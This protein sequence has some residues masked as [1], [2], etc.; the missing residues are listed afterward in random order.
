M[1]I[2]WKEIPGLPGFWASSQ[3]RIRG[4]RR[5]RVLY[6]HRKYL[7]VLI[8]NRTYTVHSLVALAFLGPRPP[9]AEIRHL[10]DDKHNNAP[11]NLAYGTPA[12]NRRDTY[13]NRR[14]LD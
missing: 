10:D 9:G 14:F 2:R 13:W 6:P 8:R 5:V 4:P 1:I 3:G 11:S 12:Q 7:Q